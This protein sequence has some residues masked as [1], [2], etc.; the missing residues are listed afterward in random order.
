MRASRF[1]RLL[2]ARGLGH[3]L[4]GRLVVGGEDEDIDD[5]GRRAALIPRKTTLL[6]ET[7][8]RMLPWMTVD[9]DYAWAGTFGESETG[10]P[11]IGPVPDMRN[12]YAVLGYGGNVITFGALAAQ[13]MRG[14]LTGDVDRDASI[15]AFG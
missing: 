6:Q 15:F 7:A 2:G 5:A 13:L 12:C 4:D 1:S 11:S 8:A 9:I 14:Y 3:P 10:L